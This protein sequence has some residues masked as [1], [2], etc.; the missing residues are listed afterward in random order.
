VRLRSR[1]LHGIG[2]TL[3]HIACSPAVQPQPWRQPYLM[4][5][6]VLR[7]RA[8]CARALRR[9]ACAAYNSE[10]QRAAVLVQHTV[11]CVEDPP[12]YPPSSAWSLTSHPALHLRTGVQCV[13]AS[14]QSFFCSHHR[15]GSVAET[16]MVAQHQIPTR[17][18]TRLY[19]HL[20][21]PR[22]VL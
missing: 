19:S 8:I 13:P 2:A 22:L 18:S 5:C 20:S 17:A 15:L 7:A 16:C 12:S 11:D 4:S 10:V 14:N 3:Y 9:R 21:F 6:S 1:D